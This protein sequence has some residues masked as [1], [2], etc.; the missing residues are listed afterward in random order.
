MI[1]INKLISFII[2]TYGIVKT[3]MSSLLE[4]MSIPN[5]STVLWASENWAAAEASRYT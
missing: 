5:P 4:V 3:I 1:I 2:C